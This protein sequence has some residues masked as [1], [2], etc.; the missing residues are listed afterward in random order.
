MENDAKITEKAHEL[1]A[2]Q[3]FKKMLRDLRI[4]EVLSLSFQYPELMRPSDHKKALKYI[5][6]FAAIQVTGMLTGVYL[7]VKLKY[8]YPG[9]FKLPLLPRFGLRLVTLALPVWMSYN[10]L[11]K[12]ERVKLNKLISD[13]HQ[14]L[15][16]L[17]NDGDISKYFSEV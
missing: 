5:R 6:T 15:V 14:R 3:G 2:Q 8:F 11:G 12:S 4:D 10:L 7:N 13:I 17:G 1:V 16:M 9:I